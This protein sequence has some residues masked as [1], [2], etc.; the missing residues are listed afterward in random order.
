MCIYVLILT[1][2]YLCAVL[3]VYA[4]T[5]MCIIPMQNLS[6]IHTYNFTN[7]I[8]HTLTHSW[9]LISLL[10]FPRK[11]KN[12]C[13]IIFFPRKSEV[14]L[15]ISM[16]SYRSTN[17]NLSCYHMTINTSLPSLFERHLDTNKRGEWNS[18]H[19]TGSELNIYQL[20]S[21]EEIIIHSSNRFN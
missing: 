5:C 14:N 8:I 10:K 13:L 15:M 18:S 11:K 3:H 21:N 17:E 16:M 12:D 7:V 2:V 20:G 4:C 19:F 6:H 9:V 1:Y